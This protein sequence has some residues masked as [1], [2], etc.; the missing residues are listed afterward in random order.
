MHLHSKS[1]VPV[2]VLKTKNLFYKVVER[3]IKH[4]LDYDNRNVRR[5]S[6]KRGEEDIYD[7][8]EV[9]KTYQAAG[10]NLSLIDYSEGSFG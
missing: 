9:F 7:V 3:I 8:Q 10:Q 4:F 1:I 6:F 5:I 2:K